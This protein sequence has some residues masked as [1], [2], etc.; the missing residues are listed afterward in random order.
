[1]AWKGISFKGYL[2]L[3]V[4]KFIISSMVSKGLYFVVES[5]FKNLH[6]VFLYPYMNNGI[7]RIR[8]VLI[9]RQ[10]G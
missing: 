4:P 5:P 10:K 9:V 3:L 7:K 2:S 6:I 1:M 8:Q